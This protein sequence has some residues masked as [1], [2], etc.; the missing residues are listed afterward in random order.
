MKLT[1]ILTGHP[2]FGIRGGGWA[3][4]VITDTEVTELGG[5]Q[6]HT[7]NNRME[8]LRGYQRTLKQ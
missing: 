7:T 3:A 6:Q 5:A 8:L 2:F 4:I 1:I